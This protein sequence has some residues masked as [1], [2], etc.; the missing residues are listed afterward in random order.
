MTGPS[1]EDTTMTPKEVLS[2]LGQMELDLTQLLA[3][4][5]GIQQIREVLQ[6]YEAV[7]GSLAKLQASEREWH[8]KIAAMEA[9]YNDRRAKQLA[10]LTDEKACCDKDAETLKAK[11][12]ET[13]AKIEEL[14]AKVEERERAVTAKLTDLDTQ[15]SQKT[16]QLTELNKAI[17]ALKS[18]FAAA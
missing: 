18:T 8:E 4:R 6:T 7:Q 14:D 9:Q 5:R 16:K 2:V 13:K 10:A 1:K 11:R 12:K 15:I 17:T 3:Q